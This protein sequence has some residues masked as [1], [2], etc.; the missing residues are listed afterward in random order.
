MAVG[1]EPRH[2]LAGEPERAAG[3][4]PGRDLQEDPALEGPD[5]DLAAEQG[6]LEGERQLALEVGAVAGEDLVRSDLDDDEQVAAA[7]RLAGQPDPRS[8]VSAPGGIVTS[9]RLPSTSTS[10]LVPW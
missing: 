6:L 3:L 9:S 8:R 2:A 7:G 4:G 5:R 1:P 10:R